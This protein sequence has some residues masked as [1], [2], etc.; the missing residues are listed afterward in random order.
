MK[1]LLLVLTGVILLFTSCNSSKKNLQRGNYDEIISKSVKK[2]IKN[3]DDNKEAVL[4]DKAFRLANERDLDAIKFLKVDGQ[5]DTWDRILQHYSMLK[6]RQ[7]QLRAILPLKLNGQLTNYKQVD[8]DFEII[9]AKRKAANY[10]YANGKRLLDSRDK[11][12]IRQAYGEFIKAKSYIGSS[13][14]DLDDLIREAQ[15]KGISRVFVQIENTSLFNFP[16]EFMAEIISGKTDRINTDWVQFYFKQSN[17]QIDFD[18]LAQVKIMNVQ[19]SPDDVKSI[20]HIYKKNIEDG[21]EYILDARGNVRKDS[22]GNDMREIKYKAIQCVMVETIQHKEARLTG[23]VEFIE[24]YPNERLIGQKPFGAESVFHHVSARAIGDI[25]A[26]DE[27][28]KQLIKIN[29][30][31]FPR[32]EELVFNNAIRVQEAINR[33]LQANQGYFK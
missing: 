14:P 4:L 8:Y 1:N 15:Y 28:A 27:E 23:E 3:P 19:V 13:F 25:N 9:D 7:N 16:P 10:F 22:A 17:N 26:L 6:N 33:I 32:D 2:L 29:Q 5:P 11:I 31:P 24:L 20:D 18:Y 30:I 21:F 12:L